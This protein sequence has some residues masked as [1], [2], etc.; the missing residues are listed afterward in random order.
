MTILLVS[1]LLL[2]TGV[3]PAEKT[4]NPAPAPPSDSEPSPDDSQ[5]VALLKEAAA[6]YDQGLLDESLA[7]L[8]QARALSS[9]PG[10]LYNIGQIQRAR[11]DCATGA[12]GLQRLLWPRPRRRTPTGSAPCAGNRRCRSVST[13]R[14]R[15]HRRRKHPAVAP[16][17]RHRFP[18]SGSQSRH[19]RRRLNGS[20]PPRPLL[21]VPIYEIR[22][23]RREPP[24]G[25]SWERAPWERARS[26]AWPL[27]SSS[28]RR[29]A[30]SEASTLNRI[31]PATTTVSIAKETP[32]PAGRWSRESGPPR[33]RPPAQPC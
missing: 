12:R 29:A 26:R 5:V 2:L 15:R 9:R 13:K 21:G 17:Y 23:R 3:A 19:R 14:R 8:Q 28:W 6:L 32:M 11:H 18:A 33:S 16:S 7:K 4:T 20:Q 30:F 22:D 27:S 10:I 24:G 25:A 31:C 1:S